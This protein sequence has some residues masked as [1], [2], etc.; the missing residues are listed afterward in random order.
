MQ[1]ACY[2]LAF[3]REEASKSDSGKQAKMA[4][5]GGES[6]ESTVSVQEGRSAPPQLNRDGFL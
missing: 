5:M 2:V 6:R 4:A 3:V 1:F